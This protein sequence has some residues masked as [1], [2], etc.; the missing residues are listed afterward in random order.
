MNKKQLEKLN[1]LVK[2]NPDLEIKIQVFTDEINDDYEWWL[3]DVK[4]ICVSDWGEY[5][6]RYY[7][8]REYL[9]EDIYDDLDCMCKKE[10]ETEAC[11]IAKE[12]MKKVILVSIDV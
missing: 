7:C 9:E 10:R 2:E 1:M 4:S 12:T 8:D 5:G 3:M 11:E 6:G